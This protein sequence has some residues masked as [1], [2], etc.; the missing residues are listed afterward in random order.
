MDLALTI[1]TL[2]I[3][4]AVAALTENQRLARPRN[5]PS[6]IAAIGARGRNTTLGGGNEKAELPQSR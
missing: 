2:R 3:V 5:A 4:A 1:S 6:R